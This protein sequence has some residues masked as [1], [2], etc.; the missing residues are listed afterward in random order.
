MDPPD[1][2]LLDLKMPDMDGPRFLEKLRKTQPDLPV[3]IVT[4]YPDSEL[5]KEATHYAPVMLVAKPADAALLER[6]VRAVAGEKMA[7][8]T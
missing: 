3:V 6:T 7:R 8:A 1:L 2:V 4:G 5:M